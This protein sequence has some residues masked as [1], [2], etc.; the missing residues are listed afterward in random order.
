MKKYT[1]VSTWVE[2]RTESAL[3]L[4]G[5]YSAST[6]SKSLVT[7]ED[8]KVSA[9][10][11][12]KQGQ[13]IMARKGEGTV[14]AVDTY[15]VY[16]EY[17][18]LVYVIPPLASV[19]GSVSP[20]TLEKLCYQYRYDGL[21]RMVEK[22]LP[23]KGWEYTVFDNKNRPILYQDEVL[24]T[25]NN[26]FETKGWIFTKY[27]VHGRIVYKGFFANGETR[28]A[29]Q[30]TLDNMAA[31]A[32]INEMRSTIPLTLNGMDIYYT[33]N[34]YPTS[35]LTILTVNYYDTYPPLPS[36]VSIPNY[37]ISQD[38]RVLKDTQ[39]IALNT[40]GLAT[41]T[42]LKNIEDNG[43][44]RNYLFYDSKGRPVG[45]HS[46]NHLGGYTKNESLLDFAGIVKQ[47]ITRH[48]RLNSDTERV[49]NQTFIHDSQN[50]LLVKKHQ[51]GSNPEEILVRNEYNDLAQ[52]TKRNVGGTDINQPLQTIDYT[53]NVRGAL[54]KVNDPSN[55]GS[56]LFG[57]ELKYSNPANLA[58]KYNGNITEID[59]KSS[60]DGVLRRYTY[61]YDNLG[62]LSAGLYSEP[63]SSIPQNN[64]YS[65][66]MSYDANGNIKTLQR[67]SKNFAGLAERVDNLSY[68]YL[69]NRLVWVI[70]QEKNYSGYPGGIGNTITYDLNGNMKDQLDKGILDIDYNFMNLPSYIEFD[71]T[72]I[73]R[74][75]NANNNVN[76]R[77]VYR[78]DG[79]KVKKTYTYG[80]GKNPVE[81]Q[82][83][84]EYFDGF[85]YEVTS[86]DDR[87]QQIL[88]IC[89][90]F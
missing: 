81:T 19:S 75:P 73:P 48:K 6:L 79:T 78:S 14:D 3:S 36:E 43:W 44:T 12:N 42:Y 57:Y 64:F 25:T 29:I 87:P 10:Y 9:E 85:Q 4:S 84:T 5:T 20:D 59:W 58:G 39:G 8:G 52:L 11:K 30:T 77:Y 62:R 28:N 31:N 82:K 56:D 83:I 13:L 55:L 37:I 86:S 72:Y 88:K 66:Y 46:I 45:T 15:Y 51:V 16:N 41:A 47:T 67:N 22:K 35:G 54:V 71:Q 90:N 17:G 24:G 2:G 40:K 63:A 60:V 89:S 70:G 18:H 38:Q 1:V 32:D 80:Y 33:K 23:G 74:V 49:T 34:I 27:D 50:R 69:G 26:N 61:Q 76:T 68:D 65:E 21:N 53:Y 7:D